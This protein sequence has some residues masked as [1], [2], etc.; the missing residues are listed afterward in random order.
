[1]SKL[2]ILYILSLVVLGVL[3]V[4]TVFRP[5]AS[6]RKYSE[7]QKEQLLQAEDQWIVQ[8][9][10]I[11]HE[12]EE[13]NYTIN[14]LVDGKLHEQEVLIPDGRKFT[15]IHHVYTDRIIDGNVRLTIYKEGEA[16]PFEE[17]TYYLK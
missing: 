15:Y 3:L 4:F 1:M 9:D 14:I 12:G 5:M 11:N 8:F 2:R 13:R 7:I 6:D 10:I 16:T 17:A